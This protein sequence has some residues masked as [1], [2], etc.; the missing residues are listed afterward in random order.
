VSAVISPAFAE[1]LQQQSVQLVVAR[2]EV[3][4]GGQLLTTLDIEPGS[5]VS[6]DRS[7]LIR[8]SCHIVLTDPT[9][10]LAPKTA[11]DLLA[12]YGNELVLY[13]G[14]QLSG[15]TDPELIQLGVFGIDE[16]DVDDSSDDLVITVDGSDR[17]RAVQRAGFTD[18]YTIPPATPGA[19]AL[20]Q[21]IASQPTG[22]AFEFDF[23]DVPYV[24]PS[25]P[26][27]YKPG[28]DPWEKSTEL[29]AS[30]GCELFFNRMG[31]QAGPTSQCVLLPLPDPLQAPVSWSYD[32]GSVNISLSIKRVLS[33]AKAPNYVIRDGQGSGIAAPVRGVAYDS[34]PDSP[35]YIGG[36]YGRQVDYQ[37]SSLLTSPAQANAQAA[38]DLAVALGS[39][40]TINLNAIPKP[41]HEVD[42][43]VE[44][45]RAR[46]GITLAYYVFDSFELGFGSEDLLRTSGARRLAR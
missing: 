6:V 32:E 5:S 18:V 10:E 16:C 17:A 26:I 11:E 41:D 2:A 46:A 9:G 21:L 22:I 42:D 38:V 15:A 24:T 13:R 43:V 45:T 3:W 19:Q 23:A 25:A 33:R 39:F 28:D 4:S 31:T 7:S 29:A 20:Q 1:A 44:V 36:R 8:R 34:N 14:L 35:T 37:S 30:Y 27:V 40:E 12:P